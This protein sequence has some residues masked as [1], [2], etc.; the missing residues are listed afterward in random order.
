ML[1]HRE[2]L[3]NPNA[4]VAPIPFTS[5]CLGG[6]SGSSQTS[7]FIKDPQMVP[8]CS[9]VREPLK[10]AIAL[11]KTQIFCFHWSALGPRWVLG[12]GIL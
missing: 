4:Q 7:V 12:T 6:C 11:D 2:V 8:A 10:Y 1:D 5:E 3:K 9:R